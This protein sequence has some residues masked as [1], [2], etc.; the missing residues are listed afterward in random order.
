M[1][2]RTSQYDRVPTLCAPDA[3]KSCFACCP[4]IRPAGYEHIRHRT[5]IQR[6]LRE[7]TR[8][9]DCQNRNLHPITGFSCWALGYLDDGCRR[10]GCLLHPARHHGRDLRPLVD[11]GEKCRRESCP[12]SMT[13]LAMS[14]ESRRYWLHLGNGLNSFQYS[15]RRFNPLFRL[16]GWGQI[17]LGRVASE[18]RGTYLTRNN[19]STAYP[20]LASDLDPRTNAYLLGRII[21]NIPLEQLRAEMFSR[22]FED[23][24]SVIV[25]WLREMPLD[26]QAPFTHLL[27]LDSLFLDLLRLGGGIR[28]I[29]E[30]QAQALK[31]KVDR[32][33]TDF[34]REI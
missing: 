28:R 3:E 18:Q 24:S 9:F 11:Y 20:V 25:S 27:A 4:P 14:P 12:E 19:L 26:S 8:S 5:I 29:H 17:L 10:V 32:A 21:M 30:D 7:N 22:R 31:K 23:F 33:V 1:T 2:N 16:L 13:F 34:L 6:M 15:S